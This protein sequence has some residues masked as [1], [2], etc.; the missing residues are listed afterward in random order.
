MPEVSH[1]RPVKGLPL[2]TRR[3]REKGAIIMVAVAFLTIVMTLVTALLYFAMAGSTSVRSYRQERVR[4]YAADGALNAAVQRL[5][6]TPTL[7]TTAGSCLTFTITEDLAGGEVYPMVAAGSSLTVDCAPTV[8][9]APLIDGDQGQAPRDVLLTVT[10]TF[11]PASVGPDQPL[12]CGSGGS[13]MV[14]GRARVRFEIDYGIVASVANG[15][16]NDPA[17]CT[18]ATNR[19]VVPKIISWSTKG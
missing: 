11:N 4:R 5:K 9:G 2:A 1:V 19:A 13:T 16:C 17:N 15:N 10:C 14:L 12:S 3:D 18:A 8:P 7:G 6:V